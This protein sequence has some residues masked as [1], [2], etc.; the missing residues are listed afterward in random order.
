MLS[1]WITVGV[2]V[3]V[4]VGVEGGETV[5]VGVDVAI[6]G[7]DVAVGVAVGPGA[8]V[9]RQRLWP[10]VPANTVCGLPGATSRAGA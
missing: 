6:P 9:Y 2:A 5:P 8:L 1:Q 7:D 4:G 3:G 10:S